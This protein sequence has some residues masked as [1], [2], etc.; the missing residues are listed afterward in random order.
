MSIGE[1]MVLL[2]NLLLVPVGV[3]MVIVF[4]SMALPGESIETTLAVFGSLSLVL[5]AG[6]T[7]LLVSL[8]KPQVA[9]WCQWLGAVS[10]TALMISQAM[11]QQ[12]LGIPWNN[13]EQLQVQGI[14]LTISLLLIASGRFLRAVGDKK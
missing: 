4:V 14:C 13:T 7:G 10:V 2:L 1:W 5:L 12:R 3:L 9:A 6:L 11:L 8:S